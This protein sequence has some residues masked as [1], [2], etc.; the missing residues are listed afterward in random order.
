MCDLRQLKSLLIPRQLGRRDSE[1]LKSACELFNYLEERGY[2]CEDNLSLLVDLFKAVN[3]DDLKSL[4]ENCSMDSD[5][6]RDIQAAKKCQEWLNFHY[7]EKMHYTC[8]VPWYAGGFKLPFLDVYTQLDLVKR[9][10]RGFESRDADFRTAFQTN[11]MNRRIL[12]EGQPGV[13]KSSFCRKIGM[14]CAR[15]TEPMLEKYELIIV[16]ELRQMV[17]SGDLIKAIFDQLLPNNSGVNK[18]DLHS[19]I[20][21][22]QS[23]VLIVLDGFDELKEALRGEV[24]NLVKGRYLPLAT[25][26][27]SSRSTERH[28]LIEWMDLHYI[29]KG[30]S[31]EK[32]EDCVRRYFTP[33]DDNAC[34]LISIIYAD[35]SISALAKNPLNTLLLCLLW[36]DNKGDLPSRQS[37]LYTQ[38]VMSIMYRHCVKQG[39]DVPEDGGFPL[40]Y[41]EAFIKLGEMAFNGLTN[42]KVMFERKDFEEAGIAKDSDLFKLG[43]LNQEYSIARLQPH[44]FWVFTHKS[45]QEYMA[46]YYLVQTN[47]VNDAKLLQAIITNTKLHNVCLF[48]AGMLGFEGDMLFTAFSEVLGTIEETHTFAQIF[49]LALSSL[50]ECGHP[51][52][53]VHILAGKIM[54]S[55]AIDLG[56]Y[57]PSISDSCIS[58]LIHLIRYCNNNA[59]RSSVRLTNL[60]IISTAASEQLI[61][62]LMGSSH[63]ESLGLA[64]SSDQQDE[65]MAVLKANPQLSNL[66]LSIHCDDELLRFMEFSGGIL[67]NARNLYS[68]IASLSPICSHLDIV[69]YCAN[70]TRYRSVFHLNDTLLYLSLCGYYRNEILFASIGGHIAWHST[71]RSLAIVFC[72]NALLA[73]RR[74]IL[75]KILKQNTRLRA[76]YFGTEVIGNASSDDRFRQRFNHLLC[77]WESRLSAA[78]I[79]QR[80]RASSMFY[81][82]IQQNQGL[83]VLCIEHIGDDNDLISVCNSIKCNHSMSVV[84]LIAEHIAT[85]VATTMYAMLKENKAIAILGVVSEENFCAMDEIV[86]QQAIFKKKK[87]AMAGEPTANQNGLSQFNQ[88]QYSMA[89]LL[90]IVAME[91]KDDAL[92]HHA[93]MPRL[94]SQLLDKTFPAIQRMGYYVNVWERHM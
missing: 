75:G 78:E 40:E 83:K 14:D 74:G 46:A 34:D 72:T 49:H 69:K 56:K 87:F 32:I 92:Y 6:D 35:Q 22:N 58:G 26:I 7:K 9:S 67:S 63:L 73:D 17:E 51:E 48:V 37:E 84:I 21:E 85:T 28:Q 86:T 36:E 79:K 59:G 29:I 1:N 8:P 88:V 15:S 61:N 42:D 41:K 94:Q 52:L 93:V 43:L 5:T 76:L 11:E 89:E 27:I 71:L 31:Q 64:V 10:P 33:N 4:V 91:T 20:I 38:L 30:F 16:L 82:S 45:F 77:Q 13:G 55:N 81:E 50:H 25:V 60:H 39:V 62:I 66:Q 57:I 2:I 47:Q 23:K 90:N 68:F 18:S 24:M 19:Y 53:F 65:L 70:A 80:K 12:I 54:R 3:R 44:K